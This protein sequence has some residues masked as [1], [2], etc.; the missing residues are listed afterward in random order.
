MKKLIAL[1]LC[2]CL[3]LSAAACTNAPAVGK[4]T[5]ASNQDGEQRLRIVATLQSQQI[6]F[7]SNVQHTLERL[8]KE[9]NVDLTIMDL[10][11][12]VT[13]FANV[14]DDIVAMKPDGV[15]TCGLETSTLGIHV[16]TLQD[17]HSAVTITSAGVRNLPVRCRSSEFGRVAGTR[18]QILK[19]TWIRRLSAVQSICIPRRSA[20]TRRRLQRLLHRLPDFEVVQS[21]DGGGSRSV[22]LAA[23]EDL[24]QAHPEINVMFGINA[25]SA[26]GALDA[27]R[28]I[29]RGTSADS[30]VASVDGTEADCAELKDPNSAL[31]AVAGNS[32]R[33]M[34][35]MAWNLLMQVI[36]GELPANEDYPQSLEIVSVTTDTADSWVKENFE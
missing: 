31:K 36:R 4:S 29:N 8:A 30:L 21:V 15:I 35:E 19:I 20:G 28:E 26:L 22:S 1:L 27:L 33:I 9:E 14:I 12:D 23:C 10:N 25:D 16:K 17:A 2:V 11:G 13:T 3:L 7:W 24:L 5:D 32:P 34:A 18:R 6:N